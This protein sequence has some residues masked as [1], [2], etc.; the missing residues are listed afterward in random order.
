M[1]GTLPAGDRRVQAHQQ[2]RP[3]LNAEA[4]H[5]NPL[6]EPAAAVSRP[7]RGSVGDRLVDE[8]PEELP[9]LD[10]DRPRLLSHQD[11]E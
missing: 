6:R 11:A 5:P 4:R 1:V 3:T 10:T 7:S 8:L 2:A 9:V